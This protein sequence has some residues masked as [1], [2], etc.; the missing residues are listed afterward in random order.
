MRDGVVYRDVYRKDID[1]LR[2]VAVLLVVLHHAGLTWLSG[3]FVGVDVFFVISGYLITSN[4]IKEVSVGA[5]TF[6]SF[7]A[8]RL[9][10]L[11]PAALL[12]ASFTT[13]A[14]IVL[15]LPADLIKYTESLSYMMLWLSNVYFQ[16]AT[17]GYFSGSSDLLPLLHAWSLAVEEQFYLIWPPLILFS[18][19]FLSRR[20]VGF[21]ALGLMIFALVFSCFEVVASPG[22]AYFLLPSRAFELL[23]GSCLAFYLIKPRSASPG[24]DLIFS[25]LGFSLI[26]ASALKLDGADYFP[27][28][29][30]FWP[31]LGAALLIYSGRHDARGVNG[32]LSLP[33]IVF[34]GVLSYSIYLWHWPVFSFLSYLEVDMTWPVL[35]ASLCFVLVASFL[36]WRYVENGFRWKYKFGFLK[37]TFL[38]FAIPLILVSALREVVKHGEGWPDR[39]SHG[40]LE[41][42]SY[43]LKSQDIQPLCHIDREQ[44]VMDIP[45]GC[46][47]GEG[48]GASVL[49][50]GDS[51]ANSVSGSVKEMLSA[52]SGGGSFV[53]RSSSPYLPDVE[54]YRRGVLDVGFGVGNDFLKQEVSI[55]QYDFVVMAGRWSSYYK[56]VNEMQSTNVGESHKNT[57]K[58]GRS[59][60]GYEAF[61]FGLTN[62]IEGVVASGAV[63]VLVA[64]I[65]EMGEDLGRCVLMG[66]HTGLLKECRIP[67]SDV[68]N[69]N[70][71]FLELSRRLMNK[72]ATLVVWDPKKTLCLDGFCYAEIGGYPVYA[73]DDH[74]SEKGAVLLAKTYLKTY[75]NPFLMHDV[76]SDAEVNK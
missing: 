36:T 12:V 27:G 32:V 42:M 31:C 43:R 20:S 52:V 56:G 33:W 69:R 41:V 73:D 8:R 58:A 47:L 39:F 19:S 38:F 17:S 72:Y 3:G 45:V 6:S 2:A 50:L 48:E 65:P 64:A 75:E 55:G 66:A 61:E 63:P 59:L 68:V 5:F 40:F 54:I 10:R 29:N 34:L 46:S 22:R 28:I 51:H 44:S 24:L 9:R 60:S 4:L 13:V 67:F 35:T 30:A 76:L 49:L 74:L 16:D 70:H 7:Y 57:L 14:A 37:T 71:E 25:F 21:M 26:I 23:I 53:S 62:A 11:L 18:F 15:M 1:G